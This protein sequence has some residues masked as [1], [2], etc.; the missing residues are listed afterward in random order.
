MKRPVSPGALLLL[1]PVS[2]A[3]SATLPFEEYAKRI[4]SATEVS[5]LTSE[6]FGEQVSP[7][8]GATELCTTD[9]SIPGNDGLRVPDNSFVPEHVGPRERRVLL[10]GSLG[11]GMQEFKYRIRAGNAGK[12]AA[13]PIY[14]EAIYERGLYAQGEP[15]KEIEVT[16]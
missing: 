4:K 9:I 2:T 12:F 1:L 8:N 5:P 14:T 10:Y 3:H 6:L 15:G 11:S 13:P 16:L 7:Y